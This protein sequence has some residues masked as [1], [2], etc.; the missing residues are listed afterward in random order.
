M[1]M[2]PRD[3]MQTTKKHVTQK[4]ADRLDPIAW[5]CALLPSLR[6][7]PRQR[8]GSGAPPRRLHWFRFFQFALLLALVL[9]SACRPPGPRAVLEGKKLL[10]KGQYA[11][12]IE[13]FREATVLMPTNAL[14]FNYLGLALHEAGQ[15]VDAERAYQRA[16]ALDHD[17]TEAHY[18]LGCLL[19]PQSN[20]LDQA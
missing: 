6:R 2:I 15:P 14:A 18:N 8:D 17:L 9:S 13:E 19:L 4:T 11:A 7:S 16:L 20:R 12:A 5:V 10:E 1:R 3:L